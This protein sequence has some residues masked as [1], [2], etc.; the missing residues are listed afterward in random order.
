[1]TNMYYTY[2][3]NVVAH[4]IITAEVNLPYTIE[5]SITETSASYKVNGE[6]FAS[7]EYAKGVVP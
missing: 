6:M 3:E 2:P 4:N 5:C 7:C 1:M